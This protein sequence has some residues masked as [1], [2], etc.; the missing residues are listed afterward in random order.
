MNNFTEHF[1]DEDDKN[2][3]TLVD[4]IEYIHILLSERMA[5]GFSYFEEPQFNVEKLKNFENIPFYGRE[6]NMIMRGLADTLTGQLRWN[7]NSVLHNIN[8]PVSIEAMVAACIANIY[9]PNPLWDFVSS[10]SQE[11]EKQIVRQMS[12]LV[13]WDE[14]K[15]DGVFT[16]GGKGCLTYAVKL[17]LNRSIPNNSLCGLTSTAEKEPVVIS[18]E[19]S[20]YS[21]DTACSLVGIGTANSI[22]VPTDEFGAIKLSEFSSV[23]NKLVDE[24]RPIAAIIVNGGNTLNNSSD[25]LKKMLPII[26]AR[27]E[28]LGY[29]PYIHYDMVITWAWLFFQQY[30]DKLNKLEI[31][32]DVLARIR[33]LSDLVVACR[34]AD[35]VG[36]DFH[37]TGFAPYISSLFLIQNG[38]ALHSIFKSSIQRLER[39]EYGNNFLQHHT[40]EHSRSSGSIFSAWAALQGIG[41]EGF[42]YYIANLMT[43]AETFRRELCKQK[44]ECLN[45]F[46]LSF[47]GAFFP[48]YRGISL[49]KA[50]IMAS[51]EQINNYVYRLF[52]FF[53]KGDHKYSKYVLGFLPQCCKSQFGVPISGLRIFPMSSFMTPKKAEEISK[54]LGEMKAVF[55][56]NYEF[57][58]MEIIGSKPIHVPK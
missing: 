7:A 16:F 25:D 52:E 32:A 27:E 2:F 45:P 40:I 8:P 43:V 1:L 56:E 19:E 18:S 42:Q 10:G 39:K 38:S 34:Y 13:G 20:H 46:S 50:K 54:E 47:A 3:K 31:E 6:I 36:I 12:R 51:T 37:K 26:K 5:K 28:E 41:V 44:F 53:Y 4:Q 17:G 57:C 30:D 22:R 35:S 24:G 33:K 58:N 29:R 23:Y 9:N 49:S 14:E 48:V 11:M 15:S 55:D 21:L